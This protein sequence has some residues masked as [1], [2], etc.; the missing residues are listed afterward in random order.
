[1]DLQK[2]THYFEWFFGAFL[3]VVL[4]LQYSIDVDLVGALF[5]DGGVAISVFGLIATVVGGA[6]IYRFVMAVISE[7]R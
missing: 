4:G 1:M 3:T 2:I 6:S 7:F 5:A